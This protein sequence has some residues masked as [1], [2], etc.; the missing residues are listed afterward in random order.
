MLP[1][2]LVLRRSYD[3]RFSDGITRAGQLRHCS[4]QTSGE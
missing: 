3:Y 2:T 1:S 4:V